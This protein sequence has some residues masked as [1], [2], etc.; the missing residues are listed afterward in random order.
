MIG[1]TL[2]P[3]AGL[4]FL[5]A[6][7][8]SAVICLADR[9]LP[10]RWVRERHDTAVIAIMALPLVLLIAMQPG[11]PAM[12][13]VDDPTQGRDVALS[14]PVA[15]RDA[16]ERTIMTARAPVSRPAV[17]LA[18]LFIV[19]WL[20]GSAIGAVRVVRETWLLRRLRAE[21]YRDERF[22]RV[23]LSR[24][25]P[26]AVSAALDSPM[27][28]GFRHP[29]ILVPDNGKPIPRAVL[30]HEV[31]HLVRGDVWI[32]LALRL[33]LVAFWWL[34]PARALLPIINRTREMLADSYAAE[35]T[36]EPIA[37]AHALLDVAADAQRS[38]VPAMAA[39]VHGAA[40]PAR[41]RR[42]ASAQQWRSG[43]A[44]VR[45]ELIIPV[46]LAVAWVATPRLGEAQS[47]DTDTDA[48]ERTEVGRED[49]TNLPLYA[50]ARRGRLDEVKRL[51]AAGYDPSA[52]ATGDGTALMGA[53]EGGNGPVIDYLLAAGANPNTVAPGDGTALIAAVRQ[54]ESKWVQQ[55]LD[56]GADPSLAVPGD[57]TPLIVAAHRDHQQ[58]AALLLRA[59]ADPNGP[60]PRDGNPL[61]AAAL[62]GNV[63]MTK[64]LLAAG[65][66]PNGYVYR[67]ETPL[68]NAAQQGHLDVLNVLID[69]G[70]DVSLTV[71]TPLHDPGGA[72]RSPLSEAERN[73]HSAVVER[74]RELGAKHDM[75]SDTE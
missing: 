31:A 19:L 18:T 75:P 71:A 56:A 28:V 74:L 69:A 59:G 49:D 41:V 44:W 1:A 73:G 42:L 72:F 55:L 9:C 53:I 24:P 2:L 40:L 50:A 39:A 67:D 37:L 62:M 10:S 52:A 46:A 68:I 7:A 61:I 54:G 32:A 20:V 47:V 70:A 65:A 22:D 36:G 35:V 34:L 57:G 60:S 5:V 8:F 4:V 27:L 29:M 11:P 16:S 25:T 45:F 63:A 33:T 3:A 26:I 58:I 51:V 17:P 15:M 30:E 13:P 43:K 66:D 48:T 21:S 14:Q 6:L 23:A 38:P 64:Q 12:S